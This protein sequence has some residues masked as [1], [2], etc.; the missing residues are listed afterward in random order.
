MERPLTFEPTNDVHEK[1][2]T[3]VIRQRRMTTVSPSSGSRL[4]K[5][6]DSSR[7]VTGRKKVN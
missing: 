3:G 2:H 1:A 5:I 6:A 4:K 7:N